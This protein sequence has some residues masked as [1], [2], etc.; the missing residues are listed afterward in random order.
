[1]NNTS[2]M[3]GYGK[4]DIL[5]PFLQA[6]GGRMAT[7]EE[8]LAN[9]TLPMAVASIAKRVVPSQ[10]RRH[11]LD[12]YCIDTG[13]FGN[14]QSHKNWWR[15]TR[16]E[17][18]LST[19]IRERP[20]DRLNNLRLDRT[21][22]ARGKRVVL[23]PTHPKV[24][25]AWQLG[26]SDTWLQRICDEIR[27]HT[28]RDIVVRGRPLSRHARQYQDRFQD[29]IRDDVHAV[30][31]WTSNCLV[32]AALHGIPVISLGPSAALQISRPLHEI[33]NVPDLDRDL[34]EAWLRHL[35]YGQFTQREMRLGLAWSMLHD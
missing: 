11:G 18:Q 23:I 8:I 31:A 1:M 28:D 4:A 12:W 15:I 16:N 27:R 35:S 10:A 30:V 21:R 19:A 25:E 13:Y 32:E 9:T 34:Q 5:E 7:T 20:A 22:F 14:L 33:D 26:S 2:G 6:A 29:F 17:Y 24:C 3:L